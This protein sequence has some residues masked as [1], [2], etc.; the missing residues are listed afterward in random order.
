MMLRCLG[1]S[2]AWDAPDNSSLG[3]AKPSKLV[4]LAVYFQGTRSFTPLESLTSTM[5]ELFRSVSRFWQLTNF[6]PCS[7][8]A[9]SAH[10][11]HTETPTLGLS[12]M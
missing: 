10:Q 3:L 9:A 7:L 2:A 11:D 12:T 1:S 6:L 8:S 5:L 4:N